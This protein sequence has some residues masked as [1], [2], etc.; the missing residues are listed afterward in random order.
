M[1]E[2]Q[3]QDTSQQ[4]YT[5]RYYNSASALQ[6]RLDTNPI[7][8]K[9]ENFLRGGSYVIVEDEKTKKITTKF[10]VQGVEKAN[11]EGVQGIIAYLTSI[12][13][14][15]VV[16]GNFDEER[17]EQYISELNIT[18][19]QFIVTNSTRWAIDDEDIE[20]IINFIMALSIPF[21]SRLIDNKER[22]SYG[23]TIQTQERTILGNNKN[24]NSFLGFGGN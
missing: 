9:I 1:E 4:V 16:Q 24:S 22:D 21:L 11:K 15:Q 23:D 14:P 8:E 5:N 7:T 2:N 3:N 20:Y 13:N 10:V 12:F 18:L 6:I 19:A 17:Y